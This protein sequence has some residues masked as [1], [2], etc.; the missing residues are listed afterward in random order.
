MLTKNESLNLIKDLSKPNQ[1]QLLEDFQSL[2][3]N[4][5]SSHLKYSIA[6]SIAG[7]RDSHCR[8]RGEEME[9]A[10]QR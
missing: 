6:D 2:F 10:V 8:R 9:S 1:N 4:N 3:F 5:L 7:L